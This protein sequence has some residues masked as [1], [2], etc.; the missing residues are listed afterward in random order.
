MKLSQGSLEKIT[1]YIELIKRLFVSLLLIVLSFIVLIFFLKNSFKKQLIIRPFKISTSLQNEG[2]T[3]EV[4]TSL[5][6]D[7]IKEMQQIGGSF[8]HKNKVIIPSSDN[9]VDEINVAFNNSIFSDVK[10]MFEYFGSKNSQYGNGQIIK[11]G[12]MFFMQFS[13]NNYS[14]TILNKTTINELISSAAEFTLKYIDPYNL[15]SL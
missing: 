5:F 7:K 11:V 13:L 2:Y 14:I 12:K 8:Y 4:L 1:N 6:I 3:G 15:A 10:S 9:D